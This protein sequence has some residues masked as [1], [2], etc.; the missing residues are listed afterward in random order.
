MVWLKIWIGL[1]LFQFCHNPF[2]TSSINI[3]RLCQSLLN[4]EYRVYDGK[5]VLQTL[6]RNTCY[7]Y[8]T[9]QIDNLSDFSKE[10]VLKVYKQVYGNSIP[11]FSLLIIFI[12][13]SHEQQKQII[14]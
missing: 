3:I 12:H 8:R 13:H 1:D 9:V 4:F 5:N 2:Q 7:I 10:Q 11:Y 14:M 6:N